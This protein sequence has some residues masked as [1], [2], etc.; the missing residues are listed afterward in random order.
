VDPGSAQVDPVTAQVDPG[1]AQVDAESAQ[2]DPGGAQV[3]PPKLSS[4]T[5][6]DVWQIPGVH[7]EALTAMFGRSQGHRSSQVLQRCLEDPKGYPPKLSSTTYGNVCQIPGVPPEA[8]KYDVRRRLAD[9]R[10]TP[11]SSQA[12]RTTMFGR[13]QGYPPKLTSGTYADVW[14]IPGVPP[15]A[16]KYDVRRCLGDPSGTPRSS[17]VRRTAMFGRSQVSHPKHS[18]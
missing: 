15:E 11:R 18:S 16:L 9:P 8:P 7:P 1:T 5:Y 12:R 13:S 2:V 10:G 6:G 3:D 14:Q 4:T 17:Q